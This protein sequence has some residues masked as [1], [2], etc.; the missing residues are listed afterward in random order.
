MI[1]QIPKGVHSCSKIRKWSVPKL[2][3]Y[4][5]DRNYTD[6]LTIYFQRIGDIPLLTSE[7]Q[8]QLA[9][10]MD[11][12][13]RRLRHQLHAFGFVTLE[14]IR[15]LDECIAA[16]SI[17]S[18]FFLP[19][20]LSRYRNP[21]GELRGVMCSWRGELIYKYNVLY[22]AFH[23]GKDCREPRRELANTLSKIDVSN[24]ILQDH[25]QITL[26]LVRI[27]QHCIG[28]NGKFVF[29]PVP[30]SPTQRKQLEDSFLMTYDELCVRIQE[31]FVT[32]E[33]L[34]HMYLKMA[35][36]NLRLV[37][38]I[39]QRYRNRGLSFNDLIQ[40]GNLG[41]LRALGKYDY[42]LGNKFSTYASWWIK[43]S[44]SRA[45]AEQPRMIRIPV[46]LVVV[47]NT[48]NWAEQRFIQSHGRVPDI[49]ELAAAVEMPVARTRAIRK[50]LFRIISLQTPILTNDDSVMV[51]ELIEN[52]NA[53]AQ[54][55]DFTRKIVYE[56]LYAMLAT[57]PERERQIVILRYG[58]YGNPSCSLLEIARRFNLSRER[59]R[60]L[61]IK[62]LDRLR[63]PSRMK[64][65]DNCRIHFD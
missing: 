33:Q 42:R 61:L 9:C 39:A 18:E 47:I 59:I 51:G 15:L 43:Q 7:K 45:I 4:N 49:E 5:E 14:H 30:A 36:S 35:E 11:T 64:Y 32:Y 24:D 63:S 56:R 2:K 53:D 31:L 65:L 46:H 52:E 13:S 3:N 22:R 8:Q 57:L 26:N 20:S 50:L 62:S 19:S 28:F 21:S 37:I 38:S 1:R 41:L 27:V 12:I 25:F 6:S 55:K 34:Q 10:D 23:A 29:D 58:L 54:I 44:V 16:K 40:E 17:P 48:I 60:Q